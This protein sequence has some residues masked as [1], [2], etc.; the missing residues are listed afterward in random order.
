MG[1]G[2]GMGLSNIQACTDEMHVDSQPGR[3]TR[4]TA[5]VYLGPHETKEGKPANEDA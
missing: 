5:I 2:A 3:G 4:L 1:F